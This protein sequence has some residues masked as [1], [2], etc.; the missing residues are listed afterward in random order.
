MN[1]DKKKD[2]QKKD[3]QMLLDVVK[4]SAQVSMVFHGQISAAI[5]MFISLFN[6][7]LY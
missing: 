5:L 6:F 7:F 3:M 2:K 1:S 4:I